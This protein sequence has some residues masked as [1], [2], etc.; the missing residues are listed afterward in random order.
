MIFTPGRPGDRFKAK[1]PV[2]RRCFSHRLI[3][4]SDTA[5]RHT[6]SSRGIPLSTAATTRY[7]RSSEHPLIPQA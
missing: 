2:S 6:T 3:V 5:Y 1:V 4:A 7:R